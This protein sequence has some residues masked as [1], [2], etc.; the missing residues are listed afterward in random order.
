MGWTNELK[1]VLN[2]SCLVGMACNKCS[3]LL[4]E[5]DIEHS[6]YV[7]LARNE[8]GTI[9]FDPYKNQTITFR[10]EIGHETCIE[11]MEDLNNG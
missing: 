1:E 3:S 6:N 5:Q 8:E 9:G 10:S 7:V 4:T 11:D 2:P